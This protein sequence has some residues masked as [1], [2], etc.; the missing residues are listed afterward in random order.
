[1]LNNKESNE[2]FIIH[3]CVKLDFKKWNL[4]SEYAS[5]LDCIWLVPTLFFFRK[6]QWLQKVNHQSLIYRCLTCRIAHVDSQYQIWI[7]DNPIFFNRNLKTYLALS[8]NKPIYLFSSSDIKNH[9]W[10]SHLFNQFKNLTK[11]MI[12][13]IFCLKQFSF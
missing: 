10:H 4:L 12:F 8:S 5:L 2:S 11:G 6:C 13:K 7:K 3:N 9:I 1:M